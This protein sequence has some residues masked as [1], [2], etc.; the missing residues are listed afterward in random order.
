MFAP[1]TKLVL[2]T[3]GLILLSRKEVVMAQFKVLSQ[4]HVSGKN[5][6]KCRSAQHSPSSR[7]ECGTFQ[8]Q[9][10]S[11]FYSTKTFGSAPY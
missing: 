8:K 7:P 2:L 5:E 4:Q 6:E 1:F 11:A 3:R 10:R 9:S